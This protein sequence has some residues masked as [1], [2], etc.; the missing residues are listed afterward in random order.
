MD[1]KD[2]KNTPI[3]IIIICASINMIAQTIASIALVLGYDDVIKADAK[4][5]AARILQV[6]PNKELELKVIEQQG[7]INQ[8]D[9][10]LKEVENLSHKPT[11]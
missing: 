7:I 2:S 5:R 6:K 10:R 4:A 3:L 1:N 8:L 9:K 11:G